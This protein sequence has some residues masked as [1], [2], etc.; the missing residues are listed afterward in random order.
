MSKWDN[1]IALSGAVILFVGLV[2][3]FTRL[4]YAPYIYIV[5]AAMF[6]WIQTKTGYYDGKNIVLKRLKRQQLIGAILLVITGVLM[7]MTHHNEWILCLSVSAV[8][9]LYTAFR[10]PYEEEKE[11]NR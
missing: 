8:L 11:K 1:I 6:A 3:Q 2:L 4:E 9:E 7:I 10:I 5:G